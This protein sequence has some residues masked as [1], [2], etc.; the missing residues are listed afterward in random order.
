MNLNLKNKTVLLTGAGK[1]IGKKILELLIKEKVI[2]YAVTRN[3]TDFKNF[4]KNKNLYLVSGD[5]TKQSI[6]DDIF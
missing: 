5:I 4:K 2:V 3:K 1:G 6:I